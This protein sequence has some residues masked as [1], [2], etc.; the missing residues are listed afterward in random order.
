M[1]ESTEVISL[2]SP[3][4]SPQNLFYIA[5]VGIPLLLLM[6][7]GLT[8]R[9]FI[10]FLDFVY[11]RKLKKIDHDIAYF[12]D[13][14][15]QKQVLE[16]E[17]VFL[18]NAHHTGVKKVEFQEVI[19]K[20]IASSNG[21]LPL[22]AYKHAA[23]KLCKKDDGL[24]YIKLSYGFWLNWAF[25]FSYGLLVVLFAILVLIQIIVDFL[26][27]HYV[28]AFAYW[29]LLISTLIFIM[30]LTA[31]LL[32]FKKLKHLNSL[33]EAEQKRTSKEEVSN[34]STN[35]AAPSAKAISPS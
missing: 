30:V 34:D 19:L 8:P 10:E 4:L 18:I 17:R 27:H 15:V 29:L 2:L 22:N 21:K 9:N 3:Y 13:T 25:T 28:S 6:K 16:R 31:S 12:S 35:L 7:W 33:L 1:S 26:N 11:E 5:L 24:I 20:T 32:K 14:D 23:D